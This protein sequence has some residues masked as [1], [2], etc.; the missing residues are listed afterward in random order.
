MG[1]FLILSAAPSLSAA[2]FVDEQ[3]TPTAYPQGDGW[4][5]LYIQDNS[6]LNREP[7]RIMGETEDNSG[8]RP[9]TYLCETVDS[10]EC[11]KAPTISANAFLQPCSAVITNNCIE[12]VW[13]LSPDGKKISATSPVAY[14]A[15]MKWN[16]K[17]NLALNLPEG[18]S[19]AVWTIPGATHG[20]GT[21]D[22]MVQVFTSSFLNKSENSKVAGQQFVTE[23]LTVAINPVKLIT[24]QYLQQV[25]EDS[26]KSQ[27]GRGSGIGHPSIDEWRYCAMIDDGSCMQ[28]QAFPKDYKFGLK[29]KLAKKI[30]GW[31]HGRIA[32]PNVV[33]E[34]AA[35][36]GQTIQVEA[37]P[38]QVPVIGEWFK[39]EELSQPIKDYIS[40]GKVQG[41]QGRLLDRNEPTGTFQEMLEPAGEPAIEAMKL[42]L[43]QV[44]DKASA[45][46]TQWTFHNLQAGELQGA[47]PCIQKATDLAGFVTTNAGAYSAGPPTFNKSTQSLDYKVISPHYTS[48]SEVA[49][50]TYD[51]RIRSEIA[52]CIYGFTNAPIQASIT[53][54]SEDGS[55]KTAT[56]VI[57]EK[58]G[59]MSLSARGFTYSSPTIRVKLSQAKSE[60]Q[61]QSTITCIKG[62]S[63]KKVTGTNPKCPSGYQKK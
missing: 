53:I 61:K 52:R 39:W 60:S 8:Q 59:W 27:N 10:P 36:K 50:G 62:K 21:T 1:V 30:T 47:S 31:L 38:V 15:A 57:N 51:L 40:A 45:S 48:K 49:L 6:A 63:Q 33:I 2:D 42:W 9:I 24:G 37:E 28:K 56:Q 43:P 20:G 19:P 55:Q 58:N 41:G 3:W 14:P 17:G 25:V 4:R 22:Y 54:L 44:K 29:I 35:N 32:S 7:S 46:P 13:A 18:G 5:S 26:S 23:R 11:V 34:T 16:F 12:S